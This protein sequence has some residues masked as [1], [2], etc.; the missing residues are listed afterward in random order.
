MHAAGTRILAAGGIGLTIQSVG[1]CVQDLIFGEKVLDSGP[2]DAGR[3]QV[4]V[5]L[6]R[7]PSACRADWML[8]GNVHAVVGRLGPRGFA[9]R[10]FY[11]LL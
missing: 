4:A 3:H 9:R 5:G 7:E 11:K 8:R 2:A 6:C 10:H 1:K